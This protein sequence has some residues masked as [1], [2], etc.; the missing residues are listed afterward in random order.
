MG[1][2]YSPASPQPSYGAVGQYSAIVGAANAAPITEAAG[3]KVI[4]VNNDTLSHLAHTASG[5][6]TSGFPSQV[7][8]FPN[9]SGVT[10]SGTAIDS[11][12]TWSTGS[13]NEG[14]M[15]SPFTVGPPATYYFGCYYH[16][17]SQME[18][19]IISK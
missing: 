4:F 17:S 2:Q 9:S 8:P 3:S 10:A 12:S 7:F 14:A 15:S 5:F 11:G 18:D 1:F 13:I 6:G 19:V 16:Y